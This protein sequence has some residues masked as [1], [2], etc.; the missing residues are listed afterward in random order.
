MNTKIGDTRKFTFDNRTFII[1]EILEPISFKMDWLWNTGSCPF[2]K[3]KLDR[4]ITHEF[5]RIEILLASEI[6][7]N[8]ATLKDII[9]LGNT[10]DSRLMLVQE[11]KYIKKVLK[12]SNKFKYLIGA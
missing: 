6:G 3:E 2:C 4:I 1:E 7:E 11:D 8:K 10:I 5:Y 9:I 12:L